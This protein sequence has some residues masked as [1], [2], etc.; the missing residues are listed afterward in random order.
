MM[1]AAAAIS[2]DNSSTESHPALLLAS[3]SRRKALSR[4]SLARSLC[5]LSIC[6]TDAS[7]SWFQTCRFTE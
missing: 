5:P 1:T 4:T 7:D 6:A 3:S 2:A